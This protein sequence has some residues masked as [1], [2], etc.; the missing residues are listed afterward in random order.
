[1]GLLFDLVYNKP[2]MNSVQ[3][4]FSVKVIFY[5]NFICYFIFF[6]F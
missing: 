5:E 2:T 6:G 1:M 3:S 4:I